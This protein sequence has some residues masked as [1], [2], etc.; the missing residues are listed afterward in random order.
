MD[1]IE[2]YSKYTNKELIEMLNKLHFRKDKIVYE[3]NFIK[4]ELFK[5]KY[6]L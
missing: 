5:R 4:Y 1:K 2:Y 3:I 6:N